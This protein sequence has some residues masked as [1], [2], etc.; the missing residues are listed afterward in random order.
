[1][2]RF[3]LLRPGSLG[4][5]VNF[6]VTCDESIHDAEQ[7]GDVWSLLPAHHSKAPPMVFT[8]NSIRSGSYVH[9]VGMLRVL[10]HAPSGARLLVLDPV[11][12][13][14]AFRHK[15]CTLAPWCRGMTL[16]MHLAPGYSILSSDDLIDSGILPEDAVFPESS[17]QNPGP[18]P[19]PQLHLSALE[20]CTSLLEG[21]TPRHPIGSPSWT[22]SGIHTDTRLRARA[23]STGR[24]GGGDLTPIGR[25]ATGQTAA[26]FSFGQPTATDSTHAQVKPPQLPAAHLEA[27]SRAAAGYT[28]AAAVSSRAAAV[29]RA[30]VNKRGSVFQMTMPSNFD[31]E[32]TGGE[33]GFRQSLRAYQENMQRLTKSGNASG[34]RGN[35]LA[36]T[37]EN[38]RE[39]RSGTA[40]PAHGRPPR[41][42]GSANPLAA[43]R[44]GASSG[45]PSGVKPPAR[46]FECEYGAE[47][48]RSGTVT[49]RAPQ[50]TFVGPQSDA[51]TGS[52]DGDSVAGSGHQA[53]TQ[54]SSPLRGIHFDFAAQSSGRQRSGSDPLSSAASR[55]RGVDTGEGQSH[56]PGGVGPARAPTASGKGGMGRGVGRA[57]AI[58]RAENPMLQPS[59]RS[60]TQSAAVG[61]GRKGK[62]SKPPKPGASHTPGS[63]PVA[64]PILESELQQEVQDA[65]GARAP[66]AEEDALEMPTRSHTVSPATITPDT[67]LLQRIVSSH[68]LNATALGAAALYDE[69]MPALGE[70]VSLEDAG[71]RTTPPLYIRHAVRGS[72][73]DAL[74]DAIIV[75]PRCQWPLC[76]GIFSTGLALAVILAFAASID[77]PVSYV[78]AG[79]AVAA[80]LGVAAW[81][82]CSPEAAFP[83]FLHG[84]AENAIQNAEVLHALH[85]ADDNPEQRIQVQSVGRLSLLSGYA[86]PVRPA[87]EG[88][89]VVLPSMFAPGRPTTILADRVMAKRVEAENPWCLTHRGPCLCA[90]SCCAHV[91]MWLCVCCCAACALGAS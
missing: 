83:K 32:D 3:V 48:G 34:G 9:A 40:G 18:L 80:S 27:A 38:P 77:V 6:S 20:A 28:P 11:S 64:M 17:E 12:E 1:M 51:A 70:S 89:L 39:Q 45:R 30:S 41:G 75:D 74:N 19:A 73:L 21:V 68:V 65:E 88:H 5:A 2:R 60:R 24:R 86:L 47:E 52:I 44:A 82:E 29:R 50:A 59:E 67:V 7:C 37:P 15:C 63:I 66:Q 8:H 76:A 46:N 31:E 57:K 87:T 35:P 56:A 33:E 55:R 25:T 4:A 58:I 91:S 42:S 72:G 78:A 61:S 71:L 13:R 10:F 26:G 54:V 81:A 23:S 16:P 84:L 14:L 49:S 22:A 62:V 90:F 36:S 79:I 69:E 43:N 85:M 53:A